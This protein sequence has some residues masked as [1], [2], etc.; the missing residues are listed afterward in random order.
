MQRRQCANGPVDSHA[1]GHGRDSTRRVTRAEINFDVDLLSLCLRHLRRGNPGGEYTCAA[2][3]LQDIRHRLS[4]FAE[5]LDI[6][7]RTD[8]PL[9]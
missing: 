8:E 2:A 4:V 6:R 5:N 7:D 3:A 1:I 9:M